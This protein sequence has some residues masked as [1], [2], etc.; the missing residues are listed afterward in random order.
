MVF[1]KYPVVLKSSSCFSKPR[2]WLLKIIFSTLWRPQFTLSCP[3]IRSPRVCPPIDAKGGG[4]AGRLPAPALHPWD[5]R[6]VLVL[7][8][9]LACNPPHSAPVLWLKA[10]EAT[11][12]M[13]GI[14][15]IPLGI[16]Y[17]DDRGRAILKE[18][19]DPGRIGKLWSSCLILAHTL[20]IAD[21]YYIV[22]GLAPGE[23]AVITRNR[24]GPAFIWPLDP[25]NGAWFQ[26]RQIMVTGSQHLRRMT[27]NTC[28][29]SP[30]SHRPGKALPGF[31]S[32]S[33][34]ALTTQTSAWGGSG[35]WVTRK[36]AE[37][38]THLLG[39]VIF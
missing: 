30:Y 4:G 32:V 37:E 24:G 13:A 27:E 9:S 21:V 19:A 35:T 10:P 23:G 25:F 3:R 31:A 26:L 16:S 33:D 14:W 18:W 39:Q 15:V 7:N 6:H 2:M 29:Q 22:G 5:P 8:L 36:Q 11:F 1:S 17:V 28:H 12:T 20:L 34:W 38:W